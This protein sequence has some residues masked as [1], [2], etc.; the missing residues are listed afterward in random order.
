L[1]RY[2]EIENRVT[3]C[4][5]R[6]EMG[7]SMVW[8]G[9]MCGQLCVSEWAKSVGKVGYGCLLWLQQLPGNGSGYHGYRSCSAAVAAA[10]AFVLLPWL[11]A[12]VFKI[13]PCCLAQRSTTVC[14]LFV[15]ICRGLWNNDEE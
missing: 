10:A 7:D 2:D 3:A 8:V 11:P 13:L 4:F 1:D 14:Y 12:I 9:E 6:I 5:K 15:K